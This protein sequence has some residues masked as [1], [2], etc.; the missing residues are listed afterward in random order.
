MS[1]AFT[2]GD[3]VDSQL[4][5]ELDKA[6]AAYLVGCEKRNAPVIWNFEEWCQESIVANAIRNNH[7]SIED[8]K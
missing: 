6:F 5:Q 2:S 1:R 4:K 7:W 8:H 3:S